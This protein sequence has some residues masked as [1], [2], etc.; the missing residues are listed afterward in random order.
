MKILKKDASITDKEAAIKEAKEEIG[1]EDLLKAIA[2][3][4]LEIGDVIVDWPADTSEH[5]TVA[6]PVS[7]FTDED[8]AKL[9]EADKEAQVDA[10]KVRSDLI[11]TLE[12]KLKKRPSTTSTRMPLSL[13]R[14]RRLR[15]LKK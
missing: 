9:D 13:I 2:D 6:E 15:R 1:K 12:K 4:D 11:A 10:A 8:Q 14:K 7:E 5:R 3:E